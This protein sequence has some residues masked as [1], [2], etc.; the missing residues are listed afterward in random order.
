[1]LSSESMAVIFSSR[2]F[3]P[4][5]D[6]TLPIQSVSENGCSSFANA[7]KRI[8]AE[9]G[10]GASRRESS[11]RAATPDA[12]SSAPGEPGTLS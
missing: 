4:R 10:A 6:T 12:L 9:R 5:A 11:S 1:M 8:V 7:T 2:C 3:D